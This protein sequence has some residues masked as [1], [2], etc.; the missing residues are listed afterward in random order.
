MRKFY[1]TFQSTL[2]GNAIFKYA[3]HL[4]TLVFLTL[5]LASNFA[6]CNSENTTQKNSPIGL[7]KYGKVKGYVDN[8]INVFKGIP[9]GDNTAKRR[10]QPPVPPI[11]WDGIKDA[12]EFGPVAP[13]QPFG[14]SNFVP[15]PQKVK[16]SEDCLNLNVWTPELHDGKNRPVMVWFHGGGYSGWTSNM[17]IFDGTNLCR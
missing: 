3:F 12:T 13:Q 1:K 7:T 2:S 6:E 17:D 4:F 9:Y 8:N 14:K 16:M 10:F 5:F 11:P 15:M